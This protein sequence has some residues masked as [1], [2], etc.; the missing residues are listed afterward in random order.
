MRLD[1]R[2]AFRVERDGA[3]GDQ[4]DGNSGQAADAGR[5]GE[6]FRRA[7][8]FSTPFIYADLH[9]AMQ[10]ARTAVV[11]QSHPVAQLVLPQLIPNPTPLAF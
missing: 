11:I 10:F 3:E 9:R 2:I 6:L 4:G 5:R 7:R 1:D 8:K